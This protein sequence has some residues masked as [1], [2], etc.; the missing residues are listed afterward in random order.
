MDDKIIELAKKAGFIFWGN[1]HWRAEGQYIDWSSDY[2][3]D[4]VRFYHLVIEDYKK[5]NNIK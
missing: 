4:L 5:E 3:D 2:D 1:E